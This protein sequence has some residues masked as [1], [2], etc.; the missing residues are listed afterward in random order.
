MVTSSVETSTTEV[1]CPYTEVQTSKKEV[2]T[3]VPSTYTSNQL[4]TKYET[5]VTESCYTT[6]VVSASTCCEAVKTKGWGGW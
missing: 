5:K 4:T 2:V 1:P 3:Q 6:Q